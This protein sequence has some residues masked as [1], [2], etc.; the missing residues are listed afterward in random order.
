M[1]IH[2]IEKAIRS[3]FSR[4]CHIILSWF[5]Y[6]THDNPWSVATD[7]STCYNGKYHNYA[8]ICIFMDFR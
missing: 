7:Y 5:C 4:T 1:E 6:F 3:H 2:V 8:V